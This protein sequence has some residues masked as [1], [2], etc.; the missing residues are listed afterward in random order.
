MNCEKIWNCEKCENDF[1]NG[2]DFC[3][4]CGFDLNVWNSDNE[5]EDDS[6]LCE[7]CYKPF[8]NGEWRQ[9]EMCDC[10][11]LDDGTLIR[12]YEYKYCEEQ[13]DGTITL[14]A[15]A[16]KHLLKKI[17][18]INEK[19]SDDEEE[20]INSL[21]KIATIIN[22]VAEIGD[23]DELQFSLDGFIKVLTEL[24]ECLN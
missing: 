17:K 21:S 16:P 11:Q 3:R 6:H 13:D 5:E 12:A 2:K 18:N 24:K 22:L 4:G 14:S 20:K 19:K 7:V 10:F 9:S 15:D 8:T 1:G 23:C